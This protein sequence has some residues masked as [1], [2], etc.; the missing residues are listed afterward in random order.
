MKIGQRVRVVPKHTYNED[1]SIKHHPEK[2]MYVRELYNPLVAGLSHKRT[3]EKH[4]Y[5]ILYEV[6]HPIKNKS[7]H[8]KR[9]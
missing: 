3:G 5:G 1:G 4:I 7:Q 8:G 9:A 6:I 2:T